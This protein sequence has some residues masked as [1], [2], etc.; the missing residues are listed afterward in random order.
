NRSGAHQNIDEAAI[1]ASVLEGN[2]EKSGRDDGVRRQN[3]HKGSELGGKSF[4]I[5]G[6]AGNHAAASLSLP[7]SAIARTIL[8]AVISSPFSSAT[9]RRSERTTTRLATAASSSNSDEM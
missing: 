8:S 2:V 5:S 4:Q 3:E 7:V 1:E 9:W 6:H